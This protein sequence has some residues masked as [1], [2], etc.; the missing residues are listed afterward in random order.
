MNQTLLPTADVPGNRRLRIAVVVALLLA[1]T[2]AHWWM[3]RD[4]ALEH[5]VHVALRKLYIMPVVLAAV[6]FNLRRF[7]RV[8]V[9]RWEG[10]AGRNG[11]PPVPPRSPT[12]H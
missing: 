12:R 9:G 8:G 3:P 7:V 1:V 2:S 4:G 6:W 10:L 11:A 5:V